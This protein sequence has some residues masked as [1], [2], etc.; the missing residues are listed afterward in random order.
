[1]SLRMVVDQGVVKDGGRSRCRRR[2]ERMVVDQGVVGTYV[3][4]SD[5]WG[6]RG[7]FFPCKNNMSMYIAQH[8][9]A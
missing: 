5:L 7:F 3:G 4:K 8:S 6:W 2:E 1:M 9:T